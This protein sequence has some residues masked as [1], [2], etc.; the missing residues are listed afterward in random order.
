MRK[1]VKDRI[2]DAIELAAE[3][4]RQVA[5]Q[6]SYGFNEQENGERVA[7][8]YDG[9]GKLL[10]RIVLKIEDVEGGQ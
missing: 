7:P 1:R 4:D 8:L 6:L 3:S 9:R 10:A 5:G 2:L